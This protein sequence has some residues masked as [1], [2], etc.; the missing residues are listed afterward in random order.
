MELG[1]LVV[2]ATWG[3]QFFWCGILLAVLAGRPPVALAAAAD[4]ATLAAEILGSFPYPMPVNAKATGSTDWCYQVETDPTLNWWAFQ[5]TVNGNQMGFNATR[6]AARIKLI[7]QA[8]AGGVGFASIFIALD[9]PGGQLRPY[10][11]TSFHILSSAEN[12]PLP[13]AANIELPNGAQPACMTLEQFLNAWLPPGVNVQDSPTCVVGQPTSAGG[14]GTTN[15]T[16][17]STVIAIPNKL[18]G[19]V[20][21]ADANTHFFWNFNGRAHEIAGAFRILL[22]VPTVGGNIPV[23]LTVGY[24][25]NSGA[26]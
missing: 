6:D 17:G 9:S 25:G 18:V 4:V 19:T 21:W 8:N 16:I 7:F 10:Q 13:P 5:P 24:G 14:C 22:T 3:K 20:D 11:A 23:Y 15:V 1:E 26:G 12:P 2:S